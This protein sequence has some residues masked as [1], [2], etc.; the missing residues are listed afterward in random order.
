MP[1]GAPGARGTWLGWSWEIS[2]ASRR[3]RRC[4]PTTSPLLG[5]SV[6]SCARAGQHHPPPARRG[7]STPALGPPA[8]WSPQ[9]RGWTKDVPPRPASSIPHAPLIWRWLG[10]RSRTDA[11]TSSLLHLLLLRLLLPRGISAGAPALQG[12]HRAARA[13]INPSLQPRALPNSPFHPNLWKSGF[14]PVKHSTI[15]R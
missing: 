13:A 11:S 7:G 4:L 3:R 1:R 9:T 8:P 5:G 6:S 12:E 10:P 2:P 15:A 14:L